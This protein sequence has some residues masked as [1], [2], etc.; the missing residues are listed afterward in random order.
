MDLLRKSVE[1][2]AKTS[3]VATRVAARPRGAK[4]KHA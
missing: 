4:R 1:Q 3:R 2:K